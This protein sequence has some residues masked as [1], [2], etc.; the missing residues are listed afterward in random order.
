MPGGV[1]GARGAPFSAL[2][3]ELPADPGGFSPQARGF[4]GL[5]GL[6]QDV[7]Q[8]VHDRG[9]FPFLGAVELLDA[10]QLPAEE[11]FGFG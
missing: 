4:G 8:I 11:A 3:A 10:T 6:I 1:A 5:A 7:G 9:D 2:V